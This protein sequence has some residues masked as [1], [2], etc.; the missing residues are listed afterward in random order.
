M[1]W[2]PMGG[3]QGLQPQG[4]PALSRARVP[5]L[6]QVCREG[7]H[8]RGGA[9]GL[10]RSRAPGSMAMVMN[11]SGCPGCWPKPLSGHFLPL[12]KSRRAPWEEGGS[13]EVA[14]SGG[15]GFQVSSCYRHVII[16]AQPRVMLPA[17]STQPDTLAW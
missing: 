16:A 1:T 11:G 3:R 12:K 9:A 5:S 17:P 6:R 13:G 7:V 15:S 14:R 2:A 8:C 4:F 10:L